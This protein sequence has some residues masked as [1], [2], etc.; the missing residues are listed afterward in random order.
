MTRTLI[1]VY[2]AEIV[3]D[4]SAVIISSKSSGDYYLRRLKISTDSFRG[5][6]ARVSV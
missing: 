6:L 3:Q 1:Q 2:S 5:Y 4:A